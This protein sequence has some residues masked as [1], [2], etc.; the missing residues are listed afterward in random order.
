MTEIER[1]TETLAED[2]EQG[3]VI[4]MTSFPKVPFITFIEYDDSIITFSKQLTDMMFLYDVKYEDGAFDVKKVVDGMLDLAKQFKEQYNK[5]LKDDCPTSATI[6]CDKRDKTKQFYKM[7]LNG[8]FSDSSMYDFA[9]Q[10]Y[11]SIEDGYGYELLFKA[12][13][14][15]G[16]KCDTQKNIKKELKDHIDKDGYIIIY[17]GINNRSR[18]DGTSFTLNK[19]V[20]NFFAN[21][22][23]SNG[24]INKYKVHIKDILGFIDNGEEEILTENAILLEEYIQ[25]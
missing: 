2:K 8:H 16:E 13:K 25:I 20:A 3:I 4:S 17:R 15:Y 19:D 24:C 7:M 14:Y 22:W 18:E 10:S 12:I 11:A 21:R 23:N 5:F 6:F 9:L 1:I